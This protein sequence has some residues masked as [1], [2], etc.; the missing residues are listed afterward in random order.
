M[1]T[2]LVVIFGSLSLY[3]MAASGLHGHTGTGCFSG[4]GNDS[5]APFPSA[6]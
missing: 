1:K 5:P 2:L 6:I 3:A 4:A